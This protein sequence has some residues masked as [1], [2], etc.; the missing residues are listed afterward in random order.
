MLSLLIVVNLED[1]EILKIFLETAQ[2]FVIFL[3]KKIQ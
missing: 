3:K 1:L 2:Y